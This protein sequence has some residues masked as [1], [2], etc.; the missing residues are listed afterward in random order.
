MMKYL[1][2]AAVAACLLLVTT[3]ISAQLASQPDPAAVASAES[4]LHQLGESRWQEAYDS[5]QFSVDFSLF[6]ELIVIHRKDR[7]AQSNRQFAGER[8]RLGSADDETFKKTEL[9]FDTTFEDGTWTE[10]VIVSTRG[11]GPWVVEGYTIE[12]Q[13]TE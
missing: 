4:F 13:R 6:D 1:C 7:G 9:M 5:G 12:S 11:E 3:T 10:T 8:P 2:H